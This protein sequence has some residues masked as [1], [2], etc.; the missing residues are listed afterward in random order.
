[1]DCL[2]IRMSVNLHPNR[3][4]QGERGGKRVNPSDMVFEEIE[5]LE[6]IEQP[7]CL[8]A[9]EG[10]LGEICIRYSW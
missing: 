10:S 1:M 3:A 9:V 8:P 6:E 5:L 7:V 2:V 4:F